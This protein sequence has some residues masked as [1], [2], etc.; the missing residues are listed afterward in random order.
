MNAQNLASILLYLAVLFHLMGMSG[1]MVSSMGQPLQ[2][3]TLG[4]M[5]TA[6]FVLRKKKKKAKRRPRK[7]PAEVGVMLDR[8]QEGEAGK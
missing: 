6:L 7:P 2:L 8:A 3:A 5:L 4:L 1:W